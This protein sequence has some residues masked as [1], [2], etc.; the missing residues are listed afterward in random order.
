M[1]QSGNKVKLV[2]VV[3]TRP[4]IIKYSAIH[5]HL[6][7]YFDSVLIDTSQHYDRNMRDVFFDSLQIDPAD[8]TLD[9]C[10][11]G[12]V[13]Q[14]AH[15]LT[16]IERILKKEKPDIVLTFGDTN[17]TLAAT[18]AS[19]FQNISIA[20]VEAGLRSRNKSMPEERNRIVVDHLSSI[21][22]AP[23]KEAMVN[24]QEEGLA[25]RARLVGD[26]MVDSLQ[27]TLSIL[28]GEI[29]SEKSYALATIH[30]NYNTDDREKLRGI[31]RYIN[32]SPYKVVFPVHPR[33]K[34]I[35]VDGDYSN[36]EF[37]EPFGHLEFV[38][39]LSGCSLVI[40]DSG[41]IQKEAYML[42]RPCLTL[43]SETEWPETLVGGWNVL[44][45]NADKLEVMELKQ[46]DNSMYNKNIYG[47]YGVAK[48]IV[49]DMQNSFSR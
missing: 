25:E 34:Q 38:Q 35:I 29:H 39:L 49:L 13:D 5:E 41:G 17:S 14:F 44:V 2:V 30:R 37:T 12:A 21:L 16:Q 46:P 33:I 36:I 45:D 48:S 47:N 11:D 8:Y 15:M 28:K 27:R 23:S 32:S 7:E 31:L 42:R 26:I 6:K 9:V 18:M 10:I 24:L 43:R 4:Q 40:T 20:H 1:V 22:Y 19:S 3:G